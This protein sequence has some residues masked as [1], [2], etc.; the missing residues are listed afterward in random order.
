MTT[1]Y[2]PPVSS[3]LSLGEPRDKTRHDYAALGLSQNAAPELIRMALDE[4]LHNASSNSLKVWAPIHAWRALA[5][6]RAIEAI[7][8]L[9]TLLRRA[10]DHEG[11]DWVQSDL[12]E[13]LAQF[14]EEALKPL[15]NYLAD[16]KHGEWARV[17]A[18]KALSDMGE[19]HPD[20]RPKCVVWLAAQLEN[21]AE[22]TETL[23][24]F[25]IVALADL[26]AA[27]AMPSIERAFASGRVDES[28]VG[29]LEDIQIEF[30]L[31]SQREHPRKPN[32]M[33]EF[34]K[35]FAELGEKIRALEKE[36]AELRSMIN[37]MESDS[38]QPYLAPPK[39]GRN[40]PCPCG[41]GKKYKKCCL[42]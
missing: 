10:D 38:E 22:Q 17:A 37:G 42:D 29:D 21:F 30:G 2:Q 8:P 12:P 16:A 40:E 1:P 11:G 23:N 27:E 3:L 39:V 6:L 7:D 4:Q 20:L 18:S 5:Q 26:D 13:V 41:S 34:N 25:L 33:T 35:E 31:K 28:I 15:V 19:T 36:N 14:G 32:R 9:L 24:A